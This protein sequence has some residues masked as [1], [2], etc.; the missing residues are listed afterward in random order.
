M[1]R[2]LLLFTLLAAGCNYNHMKEGGPQPPMISEKDLASPDFSS[3]GPLIAVRCQRCHTSQGG[4]AE[5]STS[6]DNY[7]EVSGKI[8]RII[9]RA[10]E[11]RDMPKGNPI[12]PL[13]SQL[14]VNWYRAGSPEKQIDAG[15]KPDPELGKGPIDFAKI[16]DKIF[17]RAKCTDCHGSI[18]PDA[19][20]DL[21]D[22]DAVKGRIPELIKRI[23]VDDDHP[24]APYRK[25]APAEGETFWKWINR[26][27]PR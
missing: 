19:K 27:R 5:G 17:I 16:R 2:I 3:V 8:E 26:G 7:K 22:Y 23:W 1:Q 13:E 20:L 21:T 11:D 25:L 24:P 6:F 14:L 9:A 10:V 4:K 18:N 15:E 12:S